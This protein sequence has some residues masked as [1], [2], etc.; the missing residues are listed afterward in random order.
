MPCA[1]DRY[2]FAN[3]NAANSSQIIRLW[4]GAMME[5]APAISINGDAELAHEVMFANI[6]MEVRAGQWT[7]LLGPSGAGKSTILR[8]IAGLDTPAI[9]TG[10]IKA[11]DEV[12]LAGRVSYMAQDDLLLPW[13]TVLQNIHLGSRLRGEK[14]DFDKSM[15]IIRAVGLLDHARKLPSELS[16]G[17]RQ[18]VAL[19]RTLMED[20]PIILLD[21]PFSSLDM[22]TR[23]DMQDHA[24]EQLKGR[25]VLLVTHDPNEA[26]R[27][28]QTIYILQSQELQKTQSLTPPFPKPLADKKLFALQAKLLSA[29][30]AG[31]PSW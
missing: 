4:L 1:V 25:T 7:A 17:Q 24:A 27:L 5:T 19:A 15:R 10:Q 16:G 8:F 2:S 31:G 14:V 28:C 6:D 18:R 30:R 21:E 20:M 23:A 29:I 12:S 3:S 13:L 26:V 22:R 11:S 9:F